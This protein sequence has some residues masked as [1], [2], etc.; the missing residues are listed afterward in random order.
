MK[1]QQ[2]ILI[3]KASTCG[4]PRTYQAW[5]NFKW[6]DPQVEKEGA[7]ELP[8]ISVLGLLNA[9]IHL[10]LGVNLRY[11]H[12]PTDSTEALWSFH[13]GCFTAEAR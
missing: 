13:T 5:R 3:I 12:Y 1:K 6:N 4:T 8:G 7:S 11:P 10:F 9:L 2:L